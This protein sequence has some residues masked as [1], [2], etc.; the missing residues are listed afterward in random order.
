MKQK[1]WNIS[2]VEILEA[3]DAFHLMWSILESI[4]YTKLPPDVATLIKEYELYDEN[5]I[6]WT[7]HINTAWEEVITIDDGETYISL[8]KTKKGIEIW[9]WETQKIKITPSEDTVTSVKVRVWW[10]LH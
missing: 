2:D 10:F 9:T 8:R 7:R 6:T 5:D 1:T 3:N 4:D